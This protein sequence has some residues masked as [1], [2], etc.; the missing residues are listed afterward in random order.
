MTPLVEDEGRERRAS[1]PS[2]RGE[3]RCPRSPTP[4]ATSSRRCR[5]DAHVD[6]TGDFPGSPVRLTFHFEFSDGRIAL[7]TIRP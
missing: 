6:I 2:A 7:L 4:F 3:V 5:P 1:R